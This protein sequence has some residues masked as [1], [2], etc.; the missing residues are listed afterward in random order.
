MVYK[1]VQ[2]KTAMVYLGSSTHSTFKIIIPCY[3]MTYYM[4]S[5]QN[6]ILKIGIKFHIYPL[7]IHGFEFSDFQSVVWTPSLGNK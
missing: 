1:T 5:Y 6:I 2:A 3:L 4:L 7:K